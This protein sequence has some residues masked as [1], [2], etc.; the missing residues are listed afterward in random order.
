MPRTRLSGG[1]SLFFG[2]AGL[3]LA[4]RLQIRRSERALKNP[5]G[6]NLG[7]YVGYPVLLCRCPIIPRAS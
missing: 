5:S 4:I 1:R 3:S 2:V 6:V 7:R